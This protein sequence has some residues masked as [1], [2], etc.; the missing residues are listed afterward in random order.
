M[1][2]RDAFLSYLPLFAHDLILMPR[3]F[4]KYELGDL[5]GDGGFGVV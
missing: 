1:L 2:K 5:I 3:V 4:G